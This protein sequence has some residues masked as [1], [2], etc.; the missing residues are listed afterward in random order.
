[1]Q[2]AGKAVAAASKT[3]KIRLLNQDEEL[4]HRERMRRKSG[5]FAEEALKTRLSSI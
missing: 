3:G 1:L 5:E 2:T 4:L